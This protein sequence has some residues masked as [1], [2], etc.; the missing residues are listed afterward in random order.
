MYVYVYVYLYMC[1]YMCV[2]MNKSTNTYSLC[3][4]LVYCHWLMTSLPVDLL[5]LHKEPSSLHS[6]RSPGTADR[7][8]TDKH[9]RDRQVG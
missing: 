5:C 7:R 9:L 8:E 3:G 4:V 2:Y 1:V 6:P